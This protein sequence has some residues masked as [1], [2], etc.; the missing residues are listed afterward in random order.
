MVLKWSWR[1]LKYLHVVFKWSSGGLQ[2]MFKSSWS[3]L[4]EIS[5][6][7]SNSLQGVLK[8][9][10][11]GCHKVSK[12]ASCSIRELQF[13]S[14]NW[15]LKVLCLVLYQDQTK[16]FAYWFPI[17]KLFTL[18]FFVPKDN[19]FCIHLSEKMLLPKPDFYCFLFCKLHILHIAFRKD[20]FR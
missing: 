9:S 17:C 14:Y 20:S 7:S 6:Q 10:G 2:V 4:Q 3:N 12:H 19:I 18:H 8:P 11:S 15:I 16:D 1:S 5:K 13:E